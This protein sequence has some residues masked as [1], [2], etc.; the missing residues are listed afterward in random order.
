[1]VEGANPPP[2]LTADEGGGVYRVHAGLPMQG[3]W[4]A[5]LRAR[6]PG[7]VL[8]VRGTFPIKVR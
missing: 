3:N 4:Q 8:P 5:T 6:V 7:E 1:M 2:V